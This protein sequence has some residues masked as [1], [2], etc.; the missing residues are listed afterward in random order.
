MML[1]KKLKQVAR[2]G[3]IL[4]KNPSAIGQ[5]LGYEDDFRKEVTNKYGYED[6]LPVL[7]FLEL[8]PCFSETINPISSLSDGSS[9]TDYA[10]LKCLAKKYDHCKYL[11]IGTWRGESIANVASVAEE[12]YS[13]SLSKEDLLKRGFSEG[14][15]DTIYFFSKKLNNVVHI[16]AD[17]LK[18]NFDSLNKKY[19]VIFIDGDH[20]REA[21]ISD[22]KNAF[23]LLKD[24]NSVIV[25]HDYGH[26]PER[27]R[28]ETLLA[29]L[30]GCPPGYRKNLYHVSNTLCAIFIRGYHSSRILN[31]PEVPENIFTINIS[32]KKIHKSIDRS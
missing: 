17:S 8:I 15:V 10:L 14:M 28:W 31:F 26:T 27:I 18:F 11:E 13:V 1:T 19:D 22:T 23:N 16:G 25:W 32:A 9:P 7:D 20:S 30:D 24:E 6:G 4:L 29:I 5:I 12:C 2:I 21:I 3:K